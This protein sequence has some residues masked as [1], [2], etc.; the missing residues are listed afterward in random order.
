MIKKQ[1]RFSEQSK[2]KL[3]IEAMEQD[4]TINALVLKIVQDP[5]NWAM[6]FRHE[7]FTKSI[8]NSYILTY[9]QEFRKM[10]MTRAAKVNERFRTGN[11]ITDEM[12]INQIIDKY[13]KANYKA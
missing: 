5:K 11:K 8:N 2:L 9:T 13:A 7:R 10:F 12:I 6:E 3:K 1:V 4:I